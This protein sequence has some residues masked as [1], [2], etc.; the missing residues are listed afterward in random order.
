[1]DDAKRIWIVTVTA[2]IEMA[3]LAE[4]SGDAECIALEN[5]EDE[6]E[7]GDRIEA[8][9]RTT[10]QLPEKFVGSIPWGGEDDEVCEA[11]ALAE[12]E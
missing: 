6:P 8:C 9:A 2:E 12:G 3:V 7:W 10:T 4:S 1:M 5:Y 11:C